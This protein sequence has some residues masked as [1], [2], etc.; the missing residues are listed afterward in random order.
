MMIAPDERSPPMA[1][2]G[3][4][5]VVEL[6]LGLTASLTAALAALA[7]RRPTSREPVGRGH[8]A[9]GGLVFALVAPIVY[10][11]ERLYELWRGGRSDER[12]ILA[13]THTSYYWRVAIAVWF[14]SVCAAM[15]ISARS[16]GSK[17]AAANL[18]LAIA[19]MGALFAALAW[20]VP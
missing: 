1:S 7:W 13:T 4:G 9:L 2:G 3:G 17:H 8:I 20:L 6:L 18:A 11:A 15:V 19:T 16:G 5:A 12:L 14:A 10:E